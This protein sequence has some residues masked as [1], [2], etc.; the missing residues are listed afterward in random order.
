MI[1]RLEKR[2]SRCLRPAI[3]HFVRKAGWIALLGFSLILASSPTSQLHAGAYIFSGDANGIDIITH[4]KGYTGSGGHITLT[5]GLHSGIPNATATQLAQPIKNAIVR[6]NNLKPTTGNLVTGADNPLAFAQYDYES[7]VLHELG[8]CIGLAHVNLA[9]ESGL[10]DP[11]RNFTKSTKG[12]DN[13]FNVSATARG[14]DGTRGSHDDLR[15]DDVN[16]HWFNS[17]NNPF[18]LE[19]P[20]D[21]STYSRN[22]NDLPS[23]DTYATN[24]D[25]DVSALARYNVPNTE[26]VMQQGQYNDEE[27]QTLTADG[28]ATIRLGMSGLD[29]TAGTSDDYTF[30]LQYVGVDDS[31]DILVR[32]DNTGFAVCQTGGSFLNNDHVVITSAVVNQGPNYNWYYNQKVARDV[33]ELIGP[34]DGI[35]LEGVNQLFSWTPYEKYVVQWQLYVGLLRGAKDL[36]DSG[37]LEGSVERAQVNGLPDDG[38]TIHA[39]LYWKDLRGNWSHADYSFTAVGTASD[40]SV[41]SPGNGATLSGATQTFSWSGNGTSVADY[42]VYAGSSSGGSEY[43]DSGALGAA[44]S[45]EVTGLPTDGSTV[46]VTLWWKSGGVWDSVKYS[47]TAATLASDPSISSPSNGATLSGATQ[48]FSWSGNG[49]S[50]TDYWVYAGSSSGGSEYF[51]SG[52]LGA[53]TSVEVTG[54]PTD[55]STVHVELWWK[56]G[57]VWDSVKYSYTAAT[58]ASDPSISSPSN[59]ATLSGATQ[60][61]SWSGNGTSVA[62]YWVYAG[63]SSGGSEYFDSGALGAAT[64]V[65]VTGL[66]TDGSTVHVTL[67]WK[68][69]GVWDSVT[70][71]YTADTSLTV[72]A[73]PSI[74]AISAGNG[75]LEVSFAPANNTDQIDS[76]TLTCVDQGA[77]LAAENPESAA[78]YNF[79]SVHQ[80]SRV[81]G[82]ITY[83]NALEW[84]NSDAFKIGGHRCGTDDYFVNQT[85]DVNVSLNETAD[86]TL[87]ETKIKSAYNAV[88]PKTIVIPVHWHVIHKTDGT[89]RLSQQ[90]I[91]EQMAVLN[92]DFAG[93]TYKGKSGL[94]T[95]IRFE[96]HGDID[97]V[98]NDDWFRVR[99]ADDSIYKNSL[100]ITPDRVLNI[101][102]L[103]P[104]KDDGSEGTL[105]YARI[106][107]TGTGDAEDGI[108]M[109]HS[110]VG[111]R[112]NGYAPYDEGRTLVHEVGHYLGLLH[113]FQGGTC[114]NE[115]VSSSN[116]AVTNDLVKDTPPHDEPDYGT[117]PSSP[118]GVPSPI[119]NF[120]N[121]SQDIAL[122]TFSA[123][124]TN[125]MICSLANYRPNLYSIKDTSV[126]VSGA[127]SPLTLT[128]L[129]NGNTYSCSVVATNAAGSSSPSAAQTGV[130]VAPADPS[131]SSPSNGATL[132]GATQTFSWSGNGTSVTDYWVYAGSSSGG[133][134]YFNSGALGAATSVEVTGLPTDGSTV[135]V[136]L[137]WKSG[138]VWDSVKY[139]YTAATVASDPSISSPSN[140]ATLSGATQ[141]FSWSG[142]GTS[143]ADYWVYAGSSSGGSEYFDSGALGAATSVEVTGL[144]T[145]GSTV[146]VTLW[147]KSGGVWDSVKYSYTAATVASDP[148]ISSP[149]NGATLSGA[150]QTFSW[151][152]NGTSVADYWV[153]AGS[154]SGGSEYFDS[155]ALGAATSVEVTGLPTDG[156]TVHVTLWWKSGGVWD[157]VKYSYTAATVASDPSISS[158]SNGATL[159]GATQT[160]SWSGNGTSV[161]DYWVYA[162]SSSGGSEYF[163]SGALGAATSVEVTGLPT[164]GSTVHVELW[165]KSGGAWDSV[166]YSYTAAT[167]ASADPSISSPSNGATLSGSTNETFSWS[168]NGTSVTDYWVYAGSSSGGSEYFDS[169]ALGAATSVEV[170]GLPRDGSTVY[171]TLWWKSGGV[172]DSVTNSYTAASRP[173]HPTMSSPDRSSP[174]SGAT[175]TFEWDDQGYSVT[176]WQISA[177]HADTQ[178][179]YYDSGSLAAGIRSHVVTGL[180]TDGSSVA[181]KLSAKIDGSWRNVIYTYVAASL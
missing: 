176:E 88:T 77:R 27:Q 169:G 44:T 166:K 154:S 93:L 89:G 45:V 25:R 69:G 160:F 119:E 135:H 57:G 11:E 127:N 96:V 172:W 147:W 31:A 84:H 141:T 117:S 52:A 29:E 100:N 47:Y 140:G 42:W 116:N 164:D 128:G 78:R 167:V 15:G 76:Y 144:P 168:G 74:T 36:Y 108:V 126:S 123:E 134:E 87:L 130:P 17:T 26:A 136:E 109:L 16:L 49:T 10:N 162:G 118:C 122:T 50:V 7:V 46:H 67:W 146:H 106:P 175:Q 4:P 9:T 143:V 73:A 171:V 34:V 71:S 180:P 105:G 66:P 51:N 41:S 33:P 142:N 20:V 102:S 159:S 39:R 124:Q 6:W 91:D 75:S 28:V 79:D 107:Q 138:G 63:S 92:A 18:V 58:V 178:V 70:N 132:S 65:E 155:G 158:P 12:S 53:A 174:L 3:K 112:E 181:V 59:G 129:T 30:E 2:K 56:S 152:G 173:P 90:R 72:P 157:S 153:Y 85:S 121:Y 163:N 8:H 98:E 131:I 151:S 40:P 81:I 150:T 110:A 115:Y 177:S 139:S 149:S 137:W 99:S 95:S 114:E 54:L 14:N 82:G 43:F 148:S 35:T 156:S 21:G 104:L 60:T 145:D 37:L 80:Q 86:C 62:D 133:S 5:V 55:G 13:S 120:M 113:T 165:W 22:L 111:G 38:S 23:G 170:T 19:T 83:R 101:Y 97:Y 1:V 68:S 61:F 125:R 179:Q 64:S 161:A 103:V 24:G 94:E 48:T 32:H